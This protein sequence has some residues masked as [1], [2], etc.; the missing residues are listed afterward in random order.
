[1]MGNEKTEVIS[2]NKKE[3]LRFTK[4]NTENRFNGLKEVWNELHSVAETPVFVS[5]DW[6][7][8]WWTHFG[9]HQNRK[10]HILL[11]HEGDELIAIIPLYEGCSN[12]FGKTVQRRLNLMGDGTSLNEALGH[13]DHYGRSDFLDFIVRPGYENEVCK[14]VIERLASAE[15]QKFD[16][17]RATHVNDESFLMKH[18]APA[19]NKVNKNIGLI[20]TDICP[21]IMTTDDYEETY[22]YQI[23]SNTRRRL[24]QSLKA[25]GKENG[26][27]VHEIENEEELIREYENMRDMHQE[28]WNK[29]GYP[30]AFFDT[31]F[32]HFMK[33][34]VVR[35]YRS[36]TISFRYATDSGGYCA[37]R[38]A[39]IDN[40]KC[41]DYMGSFDYDAPSSKY[42]PGIGLLTLMIKEAHEND[43]ES[44]ELLRG[45][46][47]YKFD[48]TSEVKKNWQLVL[49]IHFSEENDRR[50]TSL[51]MK[52]AGKAYM[53]Y[54]REITVMQV[55]KINN[56]PI[57]MVPGYLKSRL[58]RVIESIK[59]PKS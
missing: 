6:L 41:Y 26:Y 25:I 59:K 37:S 42:R 17:F 38:M 32:D 56:G 44:V 47:D 22:L 7:N 40:G 49:P 58:A 30:G 13:H 55:S 31:R 43:L 35:G 51:I 16:H 5:F 54:K 45:D 1:M 48:L 34:Y 28:R 24:R 29:I 33:D 23:S 18:F 57:G 27:E 2:M 10:L 11:L 12:L 52:Y 39:L 9:K 36:N 20:E 46:E 50:F 3:Q 8:C 53:L 14:A 19:L 21:V 15:Y 4:V